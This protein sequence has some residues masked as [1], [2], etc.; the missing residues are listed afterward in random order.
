MH[1][2]FV[3]RLVYGSEITLRADAWSQ[4]FI[5]LALLCP[6]DFSYMLL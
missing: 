5:G 6:R 4:N 2:K 3:E 1:V